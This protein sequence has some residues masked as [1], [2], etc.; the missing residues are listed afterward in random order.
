MKFIPESI[1]ELKTFAVFVDS[2]GNK[3]NLLKGYRD[4]IKPG[5][6]NMFKINLKKPEVNYSVKKSA[7]KKVKLVLNY[8]EIYNFS[9]KKANVLEIGCYGGADTYAM[10]S[11]G[12]KNIDAIDIPEY[13]VRQNFKK[14][15]NNIQ[16]INE[17]SE[18]LKKLR[19]TTANLYSL[20]FHINKKVNF[21]DQDITYFNQENNY[22]LIISWETLEHIMNPKIALKNMFKALKPGGICFHEYNPFFSINGGHS[23]CTL[24]FPYGHIRLSPVDFESYIRTYRSKELSVALNFYHECLNRMVISELMQYSKEVG[25]EVLDLHRFKCIDDL[26][27]IDKSVFDQCQK[28]YPSVTLNDLISRIVWI[29]LK[30]PIHAK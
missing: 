2:K 25:F 27:V 18:F 21:F 28:N 23:L 12:A 14:N 24:D 4:L 10:A 5:W 15:E 17:Q 6:Q 9:L 11:L 19:K 7:L 29:L 22:D 8:L 30:K 3:Y 16:H 13:G 20:S 1:G 26:R